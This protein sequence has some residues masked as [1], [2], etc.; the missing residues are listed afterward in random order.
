MSTP[1]TF[2]TTSIPNAAPLGNMLGRP[3]TVKAH[4]AFLDEFS[5]LV[6]AQIFELS[7]GCNIAQLTVANN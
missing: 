1:A 7:T 4:L 5:F 2:H 3:Q 6:G